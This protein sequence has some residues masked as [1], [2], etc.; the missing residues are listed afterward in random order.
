MSIIAIMK[1]AKRILK[2]YW[3]NYAN[4]GDTFLENLQGLTTLKVYGQDEQKHIEMNEEAE[5][6]RRITMKV[7]SMQLNSINIMDTLELEI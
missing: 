7:L 5:G 4:L 3:N 6:F 2:E 1:V